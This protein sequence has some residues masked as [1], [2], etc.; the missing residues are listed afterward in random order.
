MSE[1]NRDDDAPRVVDRRAAGSP[2]ER[3]GDAAGT[4][5]SEPGRNVPPAECEEV[6]R[7]LE[8]EMPALD[9]VTF[10]LSLSTNAADTLGLLHRPGETPHPPD[11]ALARHTI[12]ILGMLQEKTRGNLSGE[13]ERILDNVLFDLRMAYVR[14]ATGCGSKPSAP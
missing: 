6:Y 13:E 5:P 11:L 12:D 4:T 14:V 1:R 7:K 8:S 9:F 10:V 2:E 3:A